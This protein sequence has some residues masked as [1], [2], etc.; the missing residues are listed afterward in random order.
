[1]TIARGAGLTTPAR[2][3][4]Q[5]F[6]VWDA[7]VFLLNVLAFLLM[8]LQAREIVGGMSPGHLGE[9][10][11]FALIVIVSL[12]LVRMAW[13]LLYGWVTRRLPALAGTGGA[14]SPR[15]SVLIGWCGMRGLLS[16]ATAFALPA[17]FPQRDLIVLTAFAVVLATLVVQGLTLAPLVRLLGLA[18]GGSEVAEVNAARAELAEAGLAALDGRSGTAAEHWRYALDTSRAAFAPS[19]DPRELREKR[20]VGLAALRR[21]RERLEELRTARRIGPEAFLALQEELDF[22]EVTLSDEERRRIEPS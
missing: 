6:A 12:I 19:A 1:M 3:R 16:L 5:S 13:V 22:L 15:V 20:E 18:D 9:A 8:G 2:S 4:I 11:R 10:A 17:D 21:Q 14:P 7:A